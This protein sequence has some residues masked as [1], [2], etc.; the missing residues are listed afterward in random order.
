MPS[1]KLSEGGINRFHNDQFPLWPMS[2]KIR[3]LTETGH[4]GRTRTPGVCRMAVIKMPRFVQRLQLELLT[5]VGVESTRKN[6]VFGNNE[7]LTEV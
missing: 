3:R 6:R 7:Q 4:D 1:G 2:L 5:R